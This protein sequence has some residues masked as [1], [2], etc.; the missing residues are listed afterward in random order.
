[1]AAI[2][3]IVLMVSIRLIAYVARRNYKNSA[4]R[5]G[6]MRRSHDAWERSRRMKYS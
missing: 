1:M 3:I 6:S 2:A 5:V 4:S